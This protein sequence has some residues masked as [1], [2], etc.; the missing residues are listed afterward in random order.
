M[1][2]LTECDDVRGTHCFKLSHVISGVS[3]ARGVS[4][5]WCLTTPASPAPGDFTEL[6]ITGTLLIKRQGTSGL[7]PMADS[8]RTVVSMKVIMYIIIYVVY[9]VY[10]ISIINYY[11]LYYIYCIIYKKDKS[12]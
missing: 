4:R 12:I 9:Y 5:V 8:T 2:L 11:I 7:G 3:P 1:V 6:L 10:I